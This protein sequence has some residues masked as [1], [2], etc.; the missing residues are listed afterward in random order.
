MPSQ[1]EFL[2]LT[3]LDA[4][5]IDW[6][7]KDWLVDTG[8]TLLVADGGAGKTLLG[9]DIALALSTGREWLTSGKH[10]KPINKPKLVWFFD[11]DG[12]PALMR[13]RLKY[14]M[15][16]YNIDSNELAASGMLKV[17]SSNGY[18]I[19]SDEFIGKLYTR[20]MSTGCTPDLI[21]F[22]ALI[23]VCSADEN[24]NSEMKKVMRDCF[25]AVA[26]RLGCA[27]IIVHHI[28][29]PSESTS[30][31]SALS[32]SRGASEIVNAVDTAWGYQKEGKDRHDRKLSLLRSRVLAENDWPESIHIDLTSS[33]DT[34]GL[35]RTYQSNPE[36]L[37]AL[38]SNIHFP[39]KSTTDDITKYLQSNGYHVT[40]SVVGR[41][42]KAIKSLSQ[43]D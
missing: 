29:K 14:M 43:S 26:T 3:D 2:D 32:R 34:W 22:D 30:M 9:L 7:I 41:A 12:S 11:E 16:G 6:L 28:S 23:A 19:D 21:I 10:D 35:T 4:K 1:I 5:P 17:S 15:N 8:I 36:K 24:S 33:D 25:R 31:R 38:I 20:A 42:C 40:R 13:R 18:R 39:P 37:Q 27:I